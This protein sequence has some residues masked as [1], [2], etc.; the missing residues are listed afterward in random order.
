MKKVYEHFE[1][2]SLTW[3]QCEGC[4]HG[5]EN[6]D[7]SKGTQFQVGFRTLFEELG[8]ITDWQAP[9]DEDSIEDY[10]TLKKFSQREFVHTGWSAQNKSDDGDDWKWDETEFLNKGWI[11]TPTPCETKQCYVHLAFH[12]CGQSPTEMVENNE[13][14]GLNMVA[15]TN[16]IIVVYP[17]SDACFNDGGEYDT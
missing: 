15:A 4:F 11:Y 3:K 5:W 10:G 7:N 6:D 2:E 1:V 13:F 9:C 12:G 17:G 16:D 8:Y 14:F